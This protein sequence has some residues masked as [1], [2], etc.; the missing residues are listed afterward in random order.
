MEKAYSNDLKKFREMCD[1]VCEECGEAEASE[2]GG[3]IV[4][5]KRDGK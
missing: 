4:I 2:E 1:E 3:E 5:S